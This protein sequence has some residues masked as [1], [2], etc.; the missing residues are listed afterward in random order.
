M[1][2]LLVTI[3]TWTFVCV[4]ETHVTGNKVLGLCGCVLSILVALERGEG[5]SSSV[6]AHFDPTVWPDKMSLQ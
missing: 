2:A 1:F 4:G 3:L 5:L 6:E